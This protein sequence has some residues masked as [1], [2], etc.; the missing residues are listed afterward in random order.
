MR[1]KESGVKKNVN[2]GAAKYPQDFTIG[3]NHGHMTHSD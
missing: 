1:I 2:N 3:R